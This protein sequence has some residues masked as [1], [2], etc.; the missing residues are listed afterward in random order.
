MSNLQRNTNRFTTT[1]QR[2]PSGTSAVILPF[3][4]SRIV[5]IVHENSKP[6]KDPM[7]I[8]KIMALLKIWATRFNERQQL[9]A[10]LLDEP[11]TVMEDAGYSLNELH[12]EVS[13]PFWRG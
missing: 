10:Q 5:R 13:K 3:P 8:L 1:P 11:Q 4:S 6:E 2:M 7:P 9:K 12:R